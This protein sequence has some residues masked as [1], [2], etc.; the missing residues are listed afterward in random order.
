MLLERLILKDFGCFEKRAFDF[1]PGLNLIYGPPGSG[2][3][4]LV[5]AVSFCLTGRALTLKV[6]VSDLVAIGKAS[7]T[8]GLE[9]EVGGE[10]YRLVR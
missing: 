10:K 5:S 8:A 4:T 2:K 9:F 6:A 7:G 1:T 3:S